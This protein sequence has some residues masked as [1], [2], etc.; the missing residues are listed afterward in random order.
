MH[1]T[2]LKVAEDALDANTTIAGA[3]RAD[4]HVRGFNLGREAPQAKVTD[5]RTAAAG[6]RCARCSEGTYRSHRGIEVGQACYLGTRYSE[7]LGCPVLDAEG[8]RVPMIIGG[9]GIGSTR[10]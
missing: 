7:P 6:D 10:L 5:L 1:R 8:K 4:Y 9:Y 2:K 3:N